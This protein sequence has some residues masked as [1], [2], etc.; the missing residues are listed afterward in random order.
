VKNSTDRVC[1][2][3]NPRS[4]GG[5]TGRRIPALKDA[6]SRAFSSWEVRE[7]RRPGHATELAAEAAAQDFTLIAAVGGDGTA[8]EVVNGL[9]D[10]DKARG[11]AAFTVIPAGTG[12][13]LIKSLGIPRNV[14]EAMA[15]VTSPAGDRASDVLIT[16][17][18]LDGRKVV[19]HCI[20]V[21]G[22][23]MNGE[24]VTRANASSKRFG[25]LA[26]FLVATLR[27]L[28]AYEAPLIAVRWVEADGT[29]RTWEGDLYGAF[30]A[31]GQYCGG[32]MWMGRG[33]SMQDGLVE[34]TI[35]PKIPNSAVP[36][37]VR[38]FYDGSLRDHDRVVFARAKEISA[39][40]V[41]AREAVM[42]DTDGEPPGNLPLQVRVLAGALVVRGVWKK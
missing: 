29:E 34:L 11:R 8:N 3:V 6:A 21:A 35:V 5:A 16:E 31:N 36:G 26:T 22:F 41:K 30:I 32:G 23:G 12:S 25:G 15:A 19:R 42:V 18:E 40:V 20:N 13:D 14:D 9:M 37:M 28:A 39:R 17:C 4:A 24:V 38:R 7:T 1:F 2:I 27:T 33:G 10:G